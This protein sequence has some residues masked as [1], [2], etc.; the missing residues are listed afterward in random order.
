MTPERYPLSFR[1]ITWALILM[2]SLWAALP[3]QA[4]A[5]FIPS[6][7]VTTVTT[8]APAADWGTI[9][10]VLESKLVQQR[11]ADIGLSREEVVQRLQ[12]LSP[13]QLHQLAAHLDEIQAGGDSGLGVLITLLVIAILVVVLL[14]ISG[15]RVIIK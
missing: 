4:L 15:H 11:L 13:R 14:Q 5:G 6:A 8:A 7:A 10:E 1:T 3:S 9:Q 12:L 2:T